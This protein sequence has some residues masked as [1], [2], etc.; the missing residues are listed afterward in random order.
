MRD[1]AIER[2]KGFGPRT[3]IGLAVTLGGGALMLWALFGLPDNALAILGVG[4]IAIFIGIFI[5]GPVL[6]RPI[7]RFIGAPLPKVRGMTGTLAHENAIRNP[8]RTAAT[9]SALMVGVAL[10]GFITIFA[11]SAK[12]SISSTLDAQLRTDYIVTS[13]SGIGMAML[14]PAVAEGMAALP[15]LGAVS[16]V[17]YRPWSSAARRS[18]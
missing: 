13:G 12:A 5:I 14:P 11:A 2:R 9:A 7:S 3:A 10:V 1:V 6:A 17:R 15:G 8:R 18:S 16:A 4:A